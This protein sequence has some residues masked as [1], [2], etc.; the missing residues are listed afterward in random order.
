MVGPDDDAVAAVFFDME[1]GR[2]LKDARL[3]AAAPEMLEA[4]RPFLPAYRAYVETMRNFTVD[5][6]TSA[7][8]R[9]SEGERKDEAEERA[10]EELTKVT[11][12]M[13]AAV[14][15]AVAKAEGRP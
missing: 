4:L 5:G 15:A 13:L 14:D 3:I 1:T 6:E 10:F 8:R 9:A 12:E 7:E 11:F 2:G